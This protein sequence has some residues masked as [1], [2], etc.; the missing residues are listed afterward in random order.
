V[1]LA[2]LAACAPRTPAAQVAREQQIVRDIRWALR[3]DPR[4]SEV[5]VVWREED[6]AL[7]GSVPDAGAAEEALRLAST[8]ARHEKVVSRLAIR[9]R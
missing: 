6:V 5:R 2:L 7:E 9:P 8:R 3:D 1:A 4:F